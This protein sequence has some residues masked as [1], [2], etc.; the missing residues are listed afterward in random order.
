MTK[1]APYLSSGNGGEFSPSMDARVDYEKYPAAV[2]RGFNLL[3]LP[4]GGL[5]FCPGTRYVTKL[6]NSAAEGALYGFVPT[7]GRGYVLIF[8][9]ANL[10]F[11]QAQAE[12]MVADVAT[13]VTN[14]YF[15][16]N[17]VGWTD[18]ST[19]TASI[20]WSAGRMR[21]T[22]AGDGYAWAEQAISVAVGDQAKL[23]VI[24]FTL[25]GSYGG[26]ATVQVGTATLGS[27]L[28][29]GDNLGLGS[30][31]VSFTPG[32]GTVYFQVISKSLVENLFIDNI[33][34]L[35]NVPLELVS[36]YLSADVTS[37]RITQSN[38]VLYIFHPD[39]APYK[40]ERRG[41]YSW[42]LVKVFFQDGPW[43]N[44]NPD[45][46]LDD[47]DLIV[48]GDFDGGIS[49]W[50]SAGDFVNY[51]GEQGVVFLRRSGD[52][53]SSLIRQ[54]V[55]TGAPAT[56]HIL[57]FQIVGSGVISFKVGT[58]SGSG[59]II[60]ETN[61]IPGWYTVSFTPGASPFWI[62]FKG[63]QKESIVGGLG[64]A[65]SFNE[66]ANLLQPSA[67]TGAAVTVTALGDFR[68][69]ASTDVGRL[70]RL[71]WP[72]REA[73]WGVITAFSTSQSVTVRVYR[74]FGSTTPTESW[75]MGAW[76]NTTGWPRAGTLY[77]QRLFAA[78]TS[79][80]PQTL[81]ASVSGDFE[82]FRPDTWI[83]GSPTVQDGD[84]LDFTLA[85]THVS[86]ILW[87]AGTRRLL[88]GTATG[89][90]AI[91]SRGPALTPT[92]F[93]AE[94]QTS[95]DGAD[96]AP[97]QIDN[98]ALFV[99]RSK[100]SVYDIG[101]NYEVDG[102]R[103]AD[104]NILADHIAGSGIE[105]IVYQ[106]KPYSMVWAR[107]TDGTL[108]C[109]TYKREQNVIG[110]TP[111][112]RAANGA[113]IAAIVEAMA[114]IPGGT[115]TGSQVYNSQKRDEVWLLVNRTVQG[116]TQRYIE[117]MEGFFIGPNRAQYATKALWQAAMLTA[118]REAF[119]VDCGGTYSGVAATNISGATWLEGQTVKVLADGLVVADRVISAGA[120]TVPLS[121][122][123]TT[124]HYGFGYSWEY[125]S[126]KLPYGAQQGS[127][128]GQS[129]TLTKAVMVLQDSG[130]FTHGVELKHHD[131]AAF[132]T[133]AHLAT[134]ASL[135]T[136]EAPYDTHGGYDTD[137]RLRMSGQSPL[138]WTLL[139][140]VLKVTTNEL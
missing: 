8:G 6:K 30:H 140:L 59:N 4:Q 124:I 70:I 82:N 100:Q 64:G 129:K 25:S 101:Y 20:A 92:D 131:H 87:F 77:Q 62:E 132:V 130:S 38:D 39:Y 69:F 58:S 45:I 71:E 136:G 74:D 112:T 72:G 83:E 29:K 50:T 63:D 110:W 125:R 90:W 91:S 40:L 33:E 109:M 23:H 85:A 48:N 41:D 36:P 111:V 21:L 84:A 31:T 117:V 115:A 105:Q 127:S 43:L 9:N 67:V 93:N 103:A 35:D 56:L 42:S 13:V 1:A 86:P 57:H 65:F 19:G 78:N 118:Q 44:I 37:L 137:P 133:A 73:G 53:G 55:T 113:S 102:F 12:M 80:S 98:V 75:Q 7:A 122:A 104:L 107:K 32:A 27:S 76:S 11:A 46:D 94:P 138:P 34:V 128:V 106:A 121:V 2:S 28:Y 96:I 134:D 15:A 81:W 139:G 17:I 116:V 60:A 24:R 5:T 95:V 18:R 89:Q 108:A 88:V 120:F 99:E 22:A 135:F 123:A 14:G 10:R 3:C 97:I 16:A 68:P 126:L 119:Y 79:N 66:R 61:Y 49:G 47:A 54:S 26:T 52:T 51:D 114:V